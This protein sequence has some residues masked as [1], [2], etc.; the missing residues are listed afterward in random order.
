MTRESF[1]TRHATTTVNIEHV[2]PNTVEPRSL[3]ISYSSLPTGRVGE[4]W[5]N[6]VNGT[7]KLVN[8]DM[9]D[10]CVTLSL[11][12]QHGSTL[13]GI[14]KSLLR[15]ERGRPHGFIGAVVDA[16]RKERAV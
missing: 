2:Y 10:S 7:E 11:A 15:D 4:V 6:A 3:S 8:D 14:A 1:A 9:R 12:L 16:L 13:D 5:I